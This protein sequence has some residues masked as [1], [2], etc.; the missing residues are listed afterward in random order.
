MQSAE[1]KTQRQEIARLQGAQKTYHM[2]TVDVKALVDVDVSFARG[3]FWAVMGPSGSGKSTMLN[4]LGCL[5]RLSAGRYWLQDRDVSTLD[6]DALSEVRLRH[7]GFVFQ[8]FNLVAQLSVQ[9]NIELP[10]YYRGW[11]AR[12]SAERAK[13]LAEKMH[14]SHRLHHRPA[15]LSGGQLQRVAIAR[16][17][18]NDPELLLADEPTGN[19]DSTTG[20]QIM[21]LLVEL[22]D[23]GKTIILVTHEKSIA[24]YAANYLY[25]KD[26]RIDDI[27]TNE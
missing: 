20:R 8:S 13:E 14:L 22:N 27:R 16:A 2:G 4:I 26:G 7:I 21:E 6:D 23:E 3:S 9:K 19:L 12:R 24:E 10:L 11:D 18:A 17:L 15:E 1:A 5:D 25:M